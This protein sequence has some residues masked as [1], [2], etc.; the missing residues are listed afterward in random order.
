VILPA[1]PTLYELEGSTKSVRDQ[2]GDIW[3]MVQLKAVWRPMAFIYVY[4]MFQ[5]SAGRR[6]RAGRARA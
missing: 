2:C 6:G 5:V 4:N 3:S 1:I